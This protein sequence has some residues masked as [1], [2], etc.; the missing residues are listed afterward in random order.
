MACI[1]RD[2]VVDHS[3]CEKPSLT[4]CVGINP[5]QDSG[6][7]HTSPECRCDYVPTR[8]PD[9]LDSILRK[10]GIPLVSVEFHANGT[11]E[12]SY[13]ELEPGM[14]YT[15]I[16][17]VW[18][19]CLG[20]QSRNSLFGCQLDRLLG[21]FKG[22]EENFRTS[23]MGM[24]D[25]LRSRRHSR[26]QRL[27][28]WLDVYCVPIANA[29]LTAP[30]L[31]IAA[32]T[33]MVPTYT[34]AAHVLILDSELRCLTAQTRSCR[35][36][37][38]KAL[39]YWRTR[40]WTHQ[41]V[42]LAQEPLIHSSVGQMVRND[43]PIDYLGDDRETKGRCIQMEL[44]RYN[45]HNPTIS[46]VFFNYA[47]A[48]GFYRSRTNTDAK[49]D[50]LPELARVTE[51]TAL[52]CRTWND[53]IGKTS[54][55]PADG[56]TILANLLGLSVFGLMKT[57]LALRMN[58]IIASFEMIPMSLLLD[59]HLG[60][61]GLFS[62]D[63][64]GMAQDSSWIPAFPGQLG[65]LRAPEYTMMPTAEGFR[66]SSGRFENATRTFWLV[67]VTSMSLI[68]P[69]GPYRYIYFI[70]RHFE[71]HNGLDNDMNEV[72]S[73]Q[74]C[75]DLTTSPLTAISD[76]GDCRRLVFMFESQGSRSP[77][78]RGV[79]LSILD[80][81]PDRLLASFRCSLKIKQLSPGEGYAGSSIAAEFAVP[82]SPPNLIVACGRY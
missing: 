23:F 5:D 82:R 61:L 70:T 13:V 62:G 78:H 56:H 67:M 68:E 46:D 28:F 52:F 60:D 1:T 54:S 49:F 47:F 57:P 77:W 45:H 29:D 10:G 41:E 18:A 22:I 15:A 12:L 24:E 69:E 8:N 65:R 37:A 44:R 72:N 21:Y 42:S 59:N 30:P 40:Y 3:R 53:F 50:R 19:D 79:C 71:D 11:Y 32:I 76:L 38:M 17:H 2:I 63:P 7:L 26:T 9:A 80:D 74:W 16:S 25:P 35:A 51:P 48:A 64:S 36:E 55:L 43:S 4:S 31:K 27:L 34:V 75:I 39:C 58:A 14:M 73:N 6:G 20:D 66:S 81:S 33:R